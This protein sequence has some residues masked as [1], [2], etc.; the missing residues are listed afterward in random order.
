[1]DQ[2]KPPD[3]G[4]K[5]RVCFEFAH[6]RVDEANMLEPF[7]FRSR[8][9]CRERFP[10]DINSGDAATRT[11]KVAG[12][13]RDISHAAAEIQ[14]MHAFRDAG[15]AKETIGEWID[16]GRLQREPPPL[17]VCMRKNIIP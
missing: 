17:G 10:I 15:V 9:R 8:G 5:F 14:H 2:K 12:D 3:H 4:I 1:M 16:D 7:L 11:H 13:Q 6:I